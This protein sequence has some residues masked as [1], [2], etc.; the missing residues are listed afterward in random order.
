VT[1][2][3]RQKYLQHVII[4]T[5]KRKVVKLM[6]NH[7]ADPTVATILGAVARSG[8]IRGAQL[9]MESV[10]EYRNGADPTVANILP[11]RFAIRCTAKRSVRRRLH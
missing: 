5:I 9:L 10:S 8:A 11:E 2:R 7:G 6:I 1:A 3:H 4:E